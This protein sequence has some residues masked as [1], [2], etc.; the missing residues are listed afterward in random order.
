M[1]PDESIF[2]NKQSYKTPVTIASCE[3]L[4]AQSIG[5]VAFNI[6]GQTIKMKDILNIPDLD[7][8]LLSI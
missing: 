5:N 8:N 2:I 1:T 4:Y 7:V 3:K 6:D